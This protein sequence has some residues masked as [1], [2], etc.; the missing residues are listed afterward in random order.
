MEN[1]NDIKEYCLNCPN[2]PC[3]KGCPLKNDIPAFIHEE[4][5]KKAFEILCNTT[6]LPAVC[7]RVCPHSKQCEGSC[8][9][10]FKG[11]SVAIG[12]VESFIG[13]ES[14]KHNFEIPKKIDERLKNKKVCIIGS[15]PA[16]LTAAAFLARSGVQVKIYEK[17]EKLGG[18]LVYGIPD[19]RLDKA[20]VENTIQKILDLGVEAQTNKELGKDFTL[21]ELSKEYDSVIMAIGA[22]KPNI[23]LEGKNVLSGNELLEKLNI[24]IENERIINNTNDEK[25][26]EKLIKQND[27]KKHEIPNFKGKRVAI[28]GGGNVAMDSARTLKRMGADV[29]VIY[30]RAEE[31]MPAEVKEIEAAKNEGIKFL[32]LTN[33][34][35]VKTNNKIECIKTKLIQKEGETRLSPVNIKNS[36]YEIEIDYIILATG[37]KADIEL[38]KKEKIETDK[39]GN[40][41][42]DEGYQTSIEKVYAIGDVSGQKQTIAWAAKSGKDVAERIIKNL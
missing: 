4:N 11:K 15:G 9:K 13:D 29:T 23:T 21:E 8:V 22:N 10:G 37:S 25:T 20:I 2:K 40:I 24:I 17:N 5:T 32:F 36:N 38:L 12:K 16:G 6:V 3:Q 14:I 1:L 26:R 18:L 19:F 30:R 27:K 34:L 41:K 33:I 42:I 39:D 31:Q 35:H 7:G 28:S